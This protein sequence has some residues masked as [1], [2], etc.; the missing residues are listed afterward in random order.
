M[1]YG[2]FPIK[3]SKKNQK[4]KSAKLNEIEFS[5]E[6]RVV[7]QT[8]RSATRLLGP[9]SALLASSTEHD[10]SFGAFFGSLALFSWASS[11]CVLVPCF[12]YWRVGAFK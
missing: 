3:E 9:V 11:A 5:A 10:C 4:F 8:S 1:D 12:T 6:S 7:N 2:W